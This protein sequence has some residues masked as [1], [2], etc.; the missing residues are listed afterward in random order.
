MAKRRALVSVSDKTGIVE[1]CQGLVDRGFEV[2]S[3]G[4]TLRALSD[5]GVPARQVSEV[6]GMPE[7]LD[8]RVKTLHPLIFGGILARRNMTDDLDTIAQHGMEPIDVVAV[9][10]YP[11]AETV[12]KPGATPEQI[13]EQIDIGGPSLIRAAAKNH[14]DV[15]VLVDPADYPAVIE[16]VGSERE[17]DFSALR[18]RLAGKVFAHTAGYDRLIASWMADELVRTSDPAGPDDGAGRRDGR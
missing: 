7:I 12:A 6:T 11:F 10:L 2:V 17:G 8:G 13:I 15:Y 3:T 14:R 1:F 18:A 5:A 9:N 4:G 16:A